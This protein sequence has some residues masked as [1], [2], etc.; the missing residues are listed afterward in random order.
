MLRGVR[1]AETSLVR[2]GALPASFSVISDSLIQALVP[3]GAVTGHVA[4]IDPAGSDVTDDPFQ[5][6]PLIAEVTPSP[7]PPRLDLVAVG[8]HL[9]TLTAVMSL[10]T[11][12][13]AML[14]VFD[15]SGRCLLRQ[16]IEGPGLRVRETRIDKADRLQPGVYFARLRQSGAEDRL[17]FVLLR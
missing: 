10:A 11:H 17:K 1:L 6:G 9:G 4:V 13:A 3:I 2:F 8:F 16:Q 7:S 14:D 12:E 5:I 15:L